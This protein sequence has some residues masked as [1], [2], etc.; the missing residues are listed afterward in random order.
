[1]VQD[2]ARNY[3]HC[4][5]KKRPLAFYSAQTDD[6][7]E[8]VVP[9]RCSC[10]SPAPL[11]LHVPRVQCRVMDCVGVNGTEGGRVCVYVSIKVNNMDLVYRA[12]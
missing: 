6:H 4:P 2:T 3:S 12:R 11:L 8:C 7:G 9:R 5:P 10:A 1:M